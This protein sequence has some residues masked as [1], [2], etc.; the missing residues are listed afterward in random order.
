MSSRLKDAVPVSAGVQPGATDKRKFSVQSATGTVKTVGLRDTLMACG[1]PYSSVRKWKHITLVSQ[2]HAAA[3]KAWQKGRNRPFV[4]MGGERYSSKRKYTVTCE[5]TEIDV[6][7]AKRIT[8]E[9]LVVERHMARD[10]IHKELNELMDEVVDQGYYYSFDALGKVAIYQANPACPYDVWPLSLRKGCSTS[11]GKP[12]KED[13]DED[14]DEDEDEDQDQDEDEDEDKDKDKAIKFPRPNEYVNLTGKNGKR[15]YFV[16]ASRLGHVI[17]NGAPQSSSWELDHI[18]ALWQ[19]HL[20]EFKDFPF[21][22]PNNYEWLEHGSIELRTKNVRDHKEAAAC[23]QL[24]KEGMNIKV[25]T[26][27]DIEELLKKKNGLVEVEEMEEDE[28]VEEEQQEEEQEEDE[29]EEEDEVDYRSWYGVMPGKLPMR[30]FT[31]SEEEPDKPFFTL[32]PPVC[33][34]I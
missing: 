19:R 25:I 3:V 16:K 20:T 21:E 27:V 7:G 15:R 13:Q 31:E 2:A 30:S 34:Y 23:K 6:V 12:E 10:P 9:H 4:V 17:V 8:K 33:C 11:S 32:Y 18:K 29:E 26:M 1:F 14:K 22:H 5:D 28:V 24:V